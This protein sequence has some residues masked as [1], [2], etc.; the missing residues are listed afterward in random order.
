M[1]DQA[2]WHPV[3]HQFLETEAFDLEEIHIIIAAFEGRAL[4]AASNRPQ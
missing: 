2:E 3:M 4:R 1:D